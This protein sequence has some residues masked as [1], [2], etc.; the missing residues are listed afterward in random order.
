MMAGEPTP[1]ADPPPT[2][3]GLAVRQGVDELLRQA[4]ALLRQGRPEQAEPLWARI[5]A[6]DPNHFDAL[7]FSGISAA[8]AGN[9]QRAVPLIRRA[10][11]SK[12]GVAA[13]HR[14]LGHAL[15]DL[16]HVDEAL[17]SYTRAIE[18]R[19]DFREAYEDRALVLAL[20]RRPADALADFDR[21]LAL[22][23]NTVRLHAYRAS[24]L[25]DLQRYAEA[26]ASC[27]RALALD[28]QCA[29]AHANMAGAM[30]Q[31]GRFAEALAGSERALA[32]EPRHAGAHAFRGAALRASRRLSEALASLDAAIALEPRNAWV[33]NQRAACLLDLQ[34]L[35]GALESCE[36]ALVLQP[37]FADAHNTRGIVLGGLRRHAEALASFDRAIAARPQTAEL[38]FNK[39][40]ALLL[41]GDFEKGWELYEYR[42]K[43]SGP[44]QCA[45]TL[46]KTTRELSGKRVLLHCEQGLGD[47]LQF[48]RYAQ[49]LREQG[50]HVILSVPRTLVALLRSLGSAIEVVL[51]GEPLPPHDLQC[52]LLS[53]PRALGTCLETIPAAVPYLRP[54]PER[55]AMW[56]ARLGTHE[57]LIGVRWQGSTG[58]V[59]IGRS[60]PLRL[61][62]PLSE[63]PG[64]RLVSLQKGAGSDQLQEARLPVMD[65]GPAFEPDGPDAFLD[66]AAVMECVELVITCDTSVAHLA[67]ALARP[68]WVALKYVPDW[69]WML[70]RE[71]CPWYPTMRLFRQ[72]RPGDWQSVFAHMRRA[73]GSPPPAPGD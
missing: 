37:D 56:R 4:E 39:G 34:R 14:H 19:A 72:P 68:T 73:L 62:E 69:R 28:P 9:P 1:L 50:A 15:R 13:V 17:G 24:V 55:V 44:P 25:I 67:G 23:V 71:D 2:P 40:A 57:R 36:R 52:P 26:A 12:P 66:V 38:Y 3:G 63:I 30:C 29:D 58:R 11:A 45:A 16:G 60:F 10:I 22:G 41:L 54:D 65:L 7:H 42:D 33:H 21:A 35:D 70:D 43:P 48:C 46:A 6:S 27:E 8:R 61:L 53:V 32:L 51:A 18:L 31:L 59:D 49:V 47:T 5:L 64:I 20:L